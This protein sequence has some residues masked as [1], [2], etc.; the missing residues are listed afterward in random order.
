ML[1][2]WFLIFLIQIF[3]CSAYP[4]QP[5]EIRNAQLVIPEKE[6]KNSTHMV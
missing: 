3:Q 6:I 5:H 1:S 4:E 2:F